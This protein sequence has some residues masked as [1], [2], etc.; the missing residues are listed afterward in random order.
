[1]RMHRRR[2]KEVMT[3]PVHWGRKSQLEP[4][5]STSRTSFM[6]SVVNL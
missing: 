5:Y 1:M 4:N 3:L 6:D 2:I